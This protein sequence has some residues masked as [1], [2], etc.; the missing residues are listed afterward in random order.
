M[1]FAFWEDLQAVPEKTVLGSTIDS[2]TRTVLHTCVSRCITYCALRQ[3]IC[4][5]GLA[6]L[7]PY[8]RL[9]TG[10][11]TIESVSSDGVA[12]ALAA[13]ESMCGSARESGR[14][15]GAAFRRKLR[16]SCSPSQRP[17]SSR[18]WSALRPWGCATRCARTQTQV[19]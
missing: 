2:R 17:A 4:A 8:N 10:D 7:K 5:S 1:R 6:F 19:G 16:G 11:R 3:W 14:S 12:S 9:L 13:A 15:R 18:Q